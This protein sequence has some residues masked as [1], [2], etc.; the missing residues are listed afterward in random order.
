MRTF[1][2]R[3]RQATVNPDKI[4]AQIGA[5]GHFEIVAH[6]LAN[7]F[8]FSNGQRP[9]VEVYVVLESTPDFPKTLKFSSAQGVSFPG[10]H[11]SAIL[12]VIKSALIAGRTVRKGE[13][14]DVAPGIQVCGFGF[15]V[16]MKQLLEAS[17]AYLLDVKG[18]DIRTVTLEE[19]C[20]IVLS[21]HL[22]MPKNS[23]KGL[24][25]RG[26]QKISLGKKILFAS[27]C[28]VLVHHE[29]DRRFGVGA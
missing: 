2:L 19:N 27:Q 5:E 20:V 16:L 10:F 14:L 6:T 29:L 13:I 17:P 8:Y 1:V 4:A 23:I 7:A 12:G 24:E 15:D 11:E 18:D 9:D 21:D 28:V 26:L 25:R 3:A 22:S